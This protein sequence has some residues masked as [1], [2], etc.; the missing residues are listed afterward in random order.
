MRQAAFQQPL[1]DGF[2]G[3]SVALRPPPPSPPCFKGWNGKASFGWS[4]PNC[5]GK[6]VSPRV[7]PMHRLLCGFVSS[8]FRSVAPISTTAVVGQTPT[9]KACGSR[10]RGPLVRAAG[11]G[12]VSLPR[13]SAGNGLGE[14]SWWPRVCKWQSQHSIGAVWLWTPDRSLPV[15][16]SAAGSKAP[17][18]CGPWLKRRCRHQLPNNR[19]LPG[20]DGH[21]GERSSPWVLTV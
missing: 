4:F 11:A 5:L 17:P 2:W 7:M 18:R 20:W 13:H 10:P 12:I 19:F 9:H 15:S 1:L 8:E 16:H 3:S 6:G 14:W 21:T